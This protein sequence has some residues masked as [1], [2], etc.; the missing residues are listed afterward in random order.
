[1]R[2]ENLKA[3]DRLGLGGA[4]KSPILLLYSIFFVTKHRTNCFCGLNGVVCT[5]L[6]VLFSLPGCLGCSGLSSHFLLNDFFWV[7][8]I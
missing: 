4:V 5:T 1:M 6:I 3:Y 7:S 2:N 8:L